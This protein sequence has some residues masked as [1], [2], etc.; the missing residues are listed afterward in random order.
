MEETTEKRTLIIA[1]AALLLIVLGAACLATFFSLGLLT[2]CAGRAVVNPASPTLTAVTAS[3]ATA[4][5][6][7]PQSPFPSA[8]PSQTPVPSTPA[9]SATQ[10][11]P[12]A[13]ALIP[14]ETAGP[15]PTLP[16]A[17]VDAWCVPW[18]AASEQ[19]VVTRVIDGV[20]FEVE[21]HGE[22]RR[23]RYIGIDLLEYQSEPQL[24]SEM[25][26]KNRQ[27]VEGKQVLLLEG[28]SKDD[29][30]ELL[31]YVLVDG[32]FANLE[33]VRSGYAVALSM[34][35]DTH[36]DRLFQEAQNGAI[37]ADRGLWGPEPTPTRTLRPPAATVSPYG[38]LVVVK[39]SQGTEW[40]EPDEFVEIF[41]SGSQPVQLEG[42]SISDNENH[43][44][45][46]PR[47]VLGPKQYCRIYTNLYAPVHCGFS[48]YKPGPIWNDDYDCAYLKDK[49]GRLVD[50]FCYE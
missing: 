11:A 5:T 19:A 15:S 18:N 28:V 17:L 2:M 40:Q 20:A 12:P 27:L 31:R 8:T 30:A 1:A 7:A 33:L 39:V 23:V 24:W 21:L 25:T 13:A 38:P 42:W 14:T 43:L 44:F 45:V 6:A 4:P 41:N 46:F 10:A 3:S 34:P 29:A 22:A 35:P 16:A 48:Y 50:Q 49:D 37:L 26:E 36:C 9:P 32:R 47:F